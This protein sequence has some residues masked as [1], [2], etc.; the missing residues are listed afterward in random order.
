MR[1]GEWWSKDVILLY[2]FIS[3]FSVFCLG[4]KVAEKALQFRLPIV[5][6]VVARAG[7]RWSEDD[8]EFT[9]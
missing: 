5:K 1:C 8:E 3:K 9:V 6:W 2:S 7:G 4:W